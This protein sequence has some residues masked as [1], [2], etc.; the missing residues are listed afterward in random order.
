MRGDSDVVV[1]FVLVPSLDNVGL[2]LDSVPVAR[3]GVIDM[4]ADGE[5]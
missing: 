3:D 2:L 5:G 4:V 1:D